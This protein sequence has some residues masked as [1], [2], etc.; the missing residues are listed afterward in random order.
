MSCVAT[1]AEWF[2]P[3]PTTSM[4]E[5]R[6]KNKYRIDS[7]R[8]ADYDYGSNGIYFV[9]ICTRQK[10]H[11]FGEI[12]GNEDGLALKPTTLGQQAVACWLV[13]PEHYPFVY[14]DEFQVMP[15]HVHGLICIDKSEERAW[16]PNAFGPQSKNLAAIIRVIK[17]G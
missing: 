8:L 4:N 6:Y 14:L 1:P 15:N 9:T 12:T 16:Q 13:I 3:Y 2:L 17:L 11:F 10:E 5:T 7:A